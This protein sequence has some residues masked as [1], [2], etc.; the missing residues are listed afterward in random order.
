MEKNVLNEL[1]IKNYASYIGISNLKWYE[2]IIND[3]NLEQLLR[4]YIERT[5]VYKTDYMDNMKELE[6]AF[7]NIILNSNN[8]TNNLIGDLS[9]VIEKYTNDYI[10]LL[11]DHPL[12]KIFIESVN[13]LNSTNFNIKDVTE[14]IKKIREINIAV[15]HKDKKLELIR[16][17]RS[18][19]DVY[20]S[21]YIN[22]IDTFEKQ[23]NALIN[24]IKV[25]DSFY[26]IFNRDAFNALTDDDKIKMIFDGILLNLTNIDSL[27]A[28]QFIKNYIDYINDNT[29][30]NIKRPIYITNIFDDELYIMSKKSE[31][32]YET[33]FYISLML[34][35]KM[36]ELPNVRL[37]ISNNGDKKVANI[38]ATQSS[39][40]INDFELYSEL[41]EY[42]KK[43]LPNDSYFRFINPT[44]LVSLVITFGILKGLGIEDIIVKDY[45]PYRYKKVINDKQYNEEEGYDYQTRLTTK[46]LATYMRII[47][48]M[49]GINLE[50]YPDFGS[51]L[52]LKIEDNVEGKNEFINNL[53]Q[54]GYNFGKEL[55]IKNRLIQ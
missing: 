55:T 54:I 53:Y 2:D 38:L 13:K 14:D 33:P 19:D 51:E 50:N 32:W 29:F 1:F 41:Q 40:N 31:L 27:N 24:S 37:G 10:K 35:N 36:I 6:I 46:N 43:N 25:S 23:L 9:S 5:I 15:R 34:R 30:D 22:N 49:K 28:E 21:I 48:N 12:T 47:S 16:V 3:D 52:K 20:P 39:Q 4:N 45:M 26:N 18:N 7:E 8:Y 42:I 17:N 44:H 11:N